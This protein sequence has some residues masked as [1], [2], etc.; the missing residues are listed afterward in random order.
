MQQLPQR[1]DAV[2]E[3]RVA[4]SADFHQIDATPEQRFRVCE[5][6]QIRIGPLSVCPNSRATSTY[7][8]TLS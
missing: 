3:I 8:S 7:W 1:L 2:A 4:N 5:E 6:A